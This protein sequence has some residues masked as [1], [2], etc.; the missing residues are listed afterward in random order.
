MTKNKTSNSLSGRARD[1]AAK[2]GMSYT[3]ALE[4]LRTPQ[5]ERPDPQG[6]FVFPPEVERFIDGEGHIGVEYSLREFLQERAT[7]KYECYECY[8]PGSVATDP[9]SVIFTVSVFDPDLS[10]A[11]H[12]MMTS[13][14]H[15]A[16]TP[17]VVRWV[18]RVEI[19][20]QPHRV[21]VEIPDVPEDAEE[22][23]I[24]FGLTA[25]AHLAPADE[26]NGP[27]VPVLLITAEAED[28]EPH[29][30][31]FHLLDF[32]LLEDGFAL[33]GSS[34]M[35]EHG[36]SLRLEHNTGS[37]PPS[38]IAVRAATAAPDDDDKGHG[39]FFLAAVDLD[40]EW[41][42]IARHRGQVLILV[43]PV[44]PH[45]QLRLDDED[46]DDVLELLENGLVRGGWCPI[47]APTDGHVRPAEAVRAR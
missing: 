26:P 15:A 21:S 14:A 22:R 19:P 30:S 31:L 34:D 13:L 35:G 47:D 40:D 37:F 17:S 36:W 3:A 1:L 33:E 43:G 39:H 5:A 25:A 2:T 10:P 42:A 29:P 44:G 11:T 9:T 12:V 7:K 4:A 27:P 41:V 24:H 8:E 23:V 28:Y 45:T 32:H 38:W 18:V 20:Q 16:C 46:Q 6:G